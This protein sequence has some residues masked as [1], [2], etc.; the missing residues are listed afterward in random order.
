MQT[1]YASAVTHEELEKLEAVTRELPEGSALRTALS[2]VSSNVR[3]GCDVV[4]AP[5]SGQVSPAVAA[6]IIGVS[7]THLY[8]V[9]DS[10]DLPATSVGRDRRIALRDLRT[11]LVRQDEV[12]KQVAERFAHPIETR[13]AALESFKRKSR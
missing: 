8:K 13:R 6:R 5:E 3:A 12:R 9:L 7:R 4:V 1:I 2:D 11:Y 10:G